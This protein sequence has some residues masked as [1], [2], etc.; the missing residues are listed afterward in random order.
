MK[1]DDRRAWIK[2]AANLGL[3][4]AQASLAAETQVW[5][6][7]PFHGFVAGSTNS[8]GSQAKIYEIGDLAVLSVSPDLAPNELLQK[9]A[10]Q[11]LEK[12][13]PKLSSEIKWNYVGTTPPRLPRSPESDL[14]PFLPF[15]L[16]DGDPE[17]LWMSRG[18]ARASVQPEWVRIDLPYEHPIEAVQLYPLA[19]S[20]GGFP[21]EVA[22][23]I[24]PDGGHWDKG[25]ENSNCEPPK[26]SEPVSYHLEPPARAKQIR[27]TGRDFRLVNMGSASGSVGLG[28]AFALRGVSVLAPDGRDLAHIA[29][30]AKLT[31][32]SLNPAYP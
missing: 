14:Q 28:Y 29:T 18:Q 24:S 6:R 22:I 1:R 19:A 30:G 9:G 11:A 27:I 4:L 20:D 31:V 17:T 32:S 23:E 5:K 26:T 16:Q 12:I 25:Y 3:L 21:K 13:Q 2:L 10:T 8:S 15:H 7:G